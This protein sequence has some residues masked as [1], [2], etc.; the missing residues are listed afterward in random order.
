MKINDEIVR[1]Y[2]AGKSVA[3]YR[4]AWFFQRSRPFTE[5]S[6][7]AGERERATEV[8][9]A[10]L[11]AAE[12]FQPLNREVW[13]ALFPGWPAALEDACV[14]LVIGFPQPYD[15]MAM[16]DEAGAYH[17]ILDLLCWTVYLGKGNL[18]S[19]ARNLLTH[20]LC[21]ML[22]GRTIAG[23]DDDLN[24]GA[25]ADMLDALTFHEGFAHLVSYGGK[26][27]GETDWSSPPLRPGRVEGR[28]G[29]GGAG[30]VSVP[31]QLRQIL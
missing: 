20:E 3:G 7:S 28:R 25:Y 18:R 13:D 1:D 22:I 14:D 23:I 16:R 8:Y 31:G 24:G 2:L 5:P 29:R 19:I 27:L 6:Y 30:G 15:A 26:E 10:L 4:S 12:S 11:A 17:I 21:H 9:R